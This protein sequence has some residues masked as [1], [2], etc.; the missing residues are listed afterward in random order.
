MDNLWQ[1]YQANKAARKGMYFP[2]E[3]AA[4]LGVSE[5]AL[6]ADAPESVYLGSNIRDV[7]LKLHSLGEVQC[8]VRNDVCVHEKQGVYENVSLAPTSGIALNIG[9]IDLRIFPARWQHVLAVTNR[10]GGEVS[11]S[12]QFYDEF[13]TAL[14]KV[15]MRDDSRIAAW[16]ALIAEFQTDGKPQFATAELPPVEIPAPLPE[17]RIAAFQ[18]RWLKIKDVHH[19]S[20]LLETFALDRQASYPYA[21]QGMTKKLTHEAWQSVL[22]QARD[23]GIEIMIFAGNRG[24][25]QIQ[26]GKVH[27][28]V[29]A[30]EYLNVLDG[31]EEGFSMHLKDDEIVETWVVRRPVREGFVTCIEGFDSRRRTV[32][33]I[34]GRRQEGETELDEWT[35]IT[36]R[37]LADNPI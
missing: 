5:G 4:D 30:R 8:V 18:E 29:R 9:G 14:Q 35:E 3:G 24:L 19:F 22:E 25:V 10:D 7:V 15:F 37:L 26:T 23:A 36:D 12:I 34:F 31:K 6:M 17:N 33:Q 2:R 13:G 27:H 21:P 11:R 1:Q 32:I 16:D 20:G 28:I